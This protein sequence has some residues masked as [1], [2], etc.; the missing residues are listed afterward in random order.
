MVMKKDGVSKTRNME[1]SVA[2]N[3]RPSQ[4]ESGRPGSSKAASRGTPNKN[5]FKFGSIPNK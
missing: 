3:A 1:K 5:Q 4:T 2:T